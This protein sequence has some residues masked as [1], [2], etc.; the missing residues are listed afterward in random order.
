VLVVAVEDTRVTGSVGM[1]KEMV[2]PEG[3]DSEAITAV[4]C[5]DDGIAKLRGSVTVF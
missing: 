1:T 4:V 5:A 2:M 3:G